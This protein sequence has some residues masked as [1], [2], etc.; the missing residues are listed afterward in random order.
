MEN[1]MK[2]IFFL[3]TLIFLY[4]SGGCTAYF[5]VADERNVATMIDDGIIYTNVANKIDEDKEIDLLNYSISS[6]NGEVFIIGEYQ[7]RRAADKAVEIARKIKGVKKVTFYV[8][9]KKKVKKC[10]DIQNLKTTLMIKGQVFIDSPKTGKNV[11]VRMI[12][13]NAVLWGVV[14]SRSEMD[15]SVAFAEKFAGRNK[16]VNLL[17][18]KEQPAPPVVVEIHN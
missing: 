10:N 17:R 14:A 3:V 18:V 2:T 5:V 12:D 6:L 9:P 13:C 1:K 11:K 7:S 15:R 4:M 8:V 16:V